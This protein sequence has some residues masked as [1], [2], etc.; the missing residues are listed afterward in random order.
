MFEGITVCIKKEQE[1]VTE[2]NKWICIKY[3]W[4]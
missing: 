2:Q 4:V 1:V 3:Q